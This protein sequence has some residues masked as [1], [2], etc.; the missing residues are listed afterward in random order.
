ML[1]VL[2]EEGS[3]ETNT[4]RCPRVLFLGVIVFGPFLSCVLL[5]EAK[6]VTSSISR[7]LFFFSIASKL[8]MDTMTISRTFGP[9]RQYI[10]LATIVDGCKT[11]TKSD[12]DVQFERHYLPTLLNLDKFVVLNLSHEH[13]ITSRRRLDPI[14]SQ[15]VE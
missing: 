6:R 4:K 8:Q 15:T 3:E 12:H 13:R 7:Q 9:N 1:F 10:R 11:K 14:A 5:S 2:V